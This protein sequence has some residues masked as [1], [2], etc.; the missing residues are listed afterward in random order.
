MFN[1]VGSSFCLKKKRQVDWYSSVTKNQCSCGTGST[2]MSLDV[3]FFIKDRSI[4]QD[5]HQSMCCCC[6]YAEGY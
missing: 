6:S 5:I 2:V 4:A 1:L 3:K